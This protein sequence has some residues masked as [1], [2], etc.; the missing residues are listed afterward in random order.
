MGITTLIALKA[1]LGATGV[2]ERI[3]TA[4]ERNAVI[5]LSTVQVTIARD[6]VTL[7]GD[8]RSRSEYNE[9]SNAA[10]AVPG[11]VGVGGE[12]QVVLV[13]SGR[14]GFIK[15]SDTLRGFFTLVG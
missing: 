10:S 14:A 1:M 9:A 4:F 11:V 7:N 2:R 13:R 6:T 5:H 8:V 3:R 15:C 12:T